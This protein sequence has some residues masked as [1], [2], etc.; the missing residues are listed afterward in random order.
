[1][2]TFRRRAVPMRGVRDAQRHHRPCNGSREVTR[3]AHPARRPPSDL[4]DL[5]PRWSR[6][7]TTTDAAGTPHTWH[8]LDSGPVADEPLGTLL[9]V[10][11]NPTWSY[12]WRGLVA[13]PP[14]GWRVVAPDQLGMGYSER[15]DRPRTLAQRVG[16]LGDLTDA[17]G[18]TVPSSRS[19]TTGADRSRSAGRRRTRRRCAASC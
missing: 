8:V 17:L 18:L 4:P 7:I 1:M 3:S 2:I 19:P 15:A 9:C 11:G 5:D 14:P 13:D 10:H 6:L 12:L 16:D